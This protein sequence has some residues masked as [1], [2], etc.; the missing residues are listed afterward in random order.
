[1]SLLADIL[2][3]IGAGFMF[4]SALGLFRMPDV[5]T[6]LQAGTKAATLGA[7]AVILAVLVSHPHWAGKLL[8]IMLFIL[9]TS[10]VGSSTI[11]R[12]AL[13]LGSTLWSAESKESQ[14]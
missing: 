4:L 11:A 6:R 13:R 8:L 14:R 3:L 7:I 1:M 10:P 5:Y 9:L 2:L 12:S